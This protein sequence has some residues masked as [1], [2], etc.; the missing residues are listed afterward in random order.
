MAEGEVFGL[1]EASKG[2]ETLIYLAR[3]I[4]IK[5]NSNGSEMVTHGEEQ[6]GR[7]KM[8]VVA[9]HAGVRADGAILALD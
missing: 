5:D 4:T 6:Q 7:G 8:D 1:T 2:R 9:L 3:M